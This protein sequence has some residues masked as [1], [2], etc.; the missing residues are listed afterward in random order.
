MRILTVLSTTAQPDT[1]HVCRTGPQGI[2]ICVSLPNVGFG[3]TRWE[4]D[5]FVTTGTAPGTAYW[6]I[7]VR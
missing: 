7:W 3:G 1:E 6:Y 5:D 4:C 2:S